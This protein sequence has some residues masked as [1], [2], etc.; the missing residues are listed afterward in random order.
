MRCVRL[1]HLTEEEKPFHTSCFRCHQC[2]R[3]I[4]TNVYARVSDAIYC[5]A[6]QPSDA[7]DA[8]NNQEI[9]KDVVQT[10]EHDEQKLFSGNMVT[11]M[12]NMVLNSPTTEG[13][14]AVQHENPSTTAESTES[15]E[16]AY[17][18]L[19]PLTH[20][21]DEAPNSRHKRSH[22]TS[23]WLPTDP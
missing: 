16:A 14:S 6:C 9:P 5:L 12:N 4:N 15:S 21:R 3:L 17:S 11:T 10:P 13:P 20:A 2:H 22:T 7:P 18:G 19:W 8:F 1:L 23:I